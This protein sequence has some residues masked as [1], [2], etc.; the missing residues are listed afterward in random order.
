[1]RK[2]FL[3]AIVALAG[4]LPGVVAQAQAPA[5]APA[6]VPDALP[7]DIPYGMPIALERAKKVAEAAMA[8]AK[9][10]N[11]KMIVA[12]VSPSGDLV[13]FE[14]QDDAQLASIEVALSKAR[15]SAGFRRPTKVFFD[16]M[17]S[18]H[19]YI[20]TLKGAVA[21]EGGVPL[22]ENGKMVGAIGVAGGTGAQDGVIAKAGA[23]SVK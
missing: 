18:G 16:A 2:C 1:M 13:Y 19:P 9:K 15:S 4:L 11:W 5:A 22:V 8:E 14:K 12:I 10:R 21:A 20:S 3:M 6:P 23:D 17:E 7:F